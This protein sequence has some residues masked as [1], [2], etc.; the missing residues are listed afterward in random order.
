F[1]EIWWNSDRWLY[2]DG[3]KMDFDFN[4]LSCLS[5][6]KRY[7]AEG[8]IP[9]KPE[10][11]FKCVKPETGGLR[12]KWDQNVKEVVV[13]ETNVCVTRTTTPSAFMKII[14]PREFLD[15][16]LIKQDK[17]GIIA[18]MA[19][20]V[21]HPLCPPQP[22]YV[23]GQNHPCGCFCIPIPGEPCKTQL[24]SFFQTDLAG[25]LPQTVV[26]SFFPSSITGFYSNLSKAVVKLAA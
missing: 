25:S 10:D 26:D 12:E 4:S 22:S 1:D 23:R 20:N 9:A 19:T 24:L 5:F 7:K 21:E 13:I 3:E 14:S 2:R 18:T 11:V 16:V 8:V 6:L 17:D 15:V